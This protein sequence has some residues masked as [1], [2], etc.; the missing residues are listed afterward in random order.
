MR[1][2]LL[3][4]VYL[5]HVIHSRKAFDDGSIADLNVADKEA[6]ERSF[7]QLRFNQKLTENEQSVTAWF[8]NTVAELSHSLK[9]KLSFEN[10]MIVLKQNEQIN[11]IIT[12]YK[13]LEYWGKLTR[14]LNDYVHN[15]G[16]VYASHNLIDSRN[17]NLGKHL[18]NIS[19][20]VS[21]ISSFFLALLLMVDSALIASTDYADYL[22]CGLVPP[23]N[24]QYFI[25][26]FVQDFINH[27][28]VIL[29]PELKFFLKEHNICGMKID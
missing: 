18:T 21:Y 5:L 23:D 24:S 27:K 8:E 10:Y 6:F 22:D 26:G 25:A 20:H 29:H 11:E 12:R 16:V 14:R 19:Y 15:N 13:L 17:K 3:Q 4:Y 28:V 2:D 7:L 9:K 1:D